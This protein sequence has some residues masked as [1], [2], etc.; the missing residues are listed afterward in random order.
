MGLAWLG[1]TRDLRDGR[2]LASRDLG[3]IFHDT[4]ADSASCDSAHACCSHL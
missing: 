4:T 1:H 2:D 3:R